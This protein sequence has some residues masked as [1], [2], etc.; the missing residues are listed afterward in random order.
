MNE[1]F[2][3]SNCDPMLN[4]GRD[5]MALPLAI[6]PQFSYKSSMIKEHDLTTKEK[7]KTSPRP[8]TG[9]LI[10]VSKKKSTFFFCCH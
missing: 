9:V 10:Y 8:G 2:C 4:F 1:L 7:T 5:A 3:S 6:K